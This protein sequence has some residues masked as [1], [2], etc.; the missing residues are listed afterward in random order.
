MG[1]G[2]FSA[3]RAVIIEKAFGAAFDY[4]QIILSI[5][6]LNRPD[7]DDH[8]DHLALHH[9][10]I[11]TGQLIIP[12]GQFPLCLVTLLLRQTDNLFYSPLLFFSSTTSTRVAS[13]FSSNIKCKM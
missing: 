6:L 4:L 7:P 13:V 10:L 2:T 12:V 1:N 11:S 9:L 5:A 3:H 8:D